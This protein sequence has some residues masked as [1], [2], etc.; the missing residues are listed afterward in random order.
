MAPET[1]TPR[2]LM[3]SDVY[4]PRINGVSTS[5]RTFRRDLAALGC[6]SL[7]VAPAYPGAAED[8]ED[9][10]R[11]RSRYLPADPEDR[12]MVYRELGHAAREVAEGFDLVHVQTPFLAHYAGVRLGRELGIPVVETC[13]TYFE[14]YFQH[15][16][17]WIP[18]GLLRGL[19]RALTRS[20]CKHVD[21]VISPSTQMADA[22]R[23]YGVKS[24][25]EVIPTGLDMD[26][27]TAGDGARF[28]RDHGID[29][30]RPVLLNVGRVAHEKNLGFLFDVLASVRRDVPDV[31]M[32]LA[33][34]GPARTGLQARARAEGLD[35]NLCF[36]G[37]LDRD[38]ELLDCYRAADLFIFASRTE[39]QGLVL[40]EA[41]A[42]GLPVV[43]TAVMG[44]AS[45]LADAH[46]ALVAEESVAEFSDA[47]IFLLRSPQRRLEMAD[48]ARQ[49]VERNWSSREMAAR[50]LGLYQ[51][52]LAKARRPVTTRS[53]GETTRPGESAAAR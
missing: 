19:S 4:F 52:V 44:T 5:I 31:L 48:E 53:G 14:H 40:L 50:M 23:R 25:V 46:G 1:G 2:V 24:T 33:G 30:K 12:L 29:P 38:K 6:H 11:I 15:Y 35:D 36:V 41:M 18:A 13:H 34:E 28:R 32:V 21:H 7:L 17:P 51:V 10:I 26:R 37:Y 9:V 47:V 20:Q 45:V 39:T 43:S 16:L 22:L 27:F 3:L 49:F 8:T 42:T